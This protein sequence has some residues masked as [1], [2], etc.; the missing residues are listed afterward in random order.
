MPSD[1]M[2]RASRVTLR[3][4]SVT[5]SRLARSLAGPVASARAIA[6]VISA[7]SWVR[8]RSACTTLTHATGRLSDCAHCVSSV[9][10][11]L[12]AGAMNVAT[13]AP[14]RPPR[15]RR[16]PVRMTVSPC[17]HP[18]RLVGAPART[19]DS[20]PGRAI[21][22]RP[23]VV[24]ASVSGAVRRTPTD[25]RVAVPSTSGP[26]GGFRPQS[27]VRAVRVSDHRA[28]AG[29]D[30]HLR[31][32]DRREPLKVLTRPLGREGRTVLGTSSRDP[33]MS[34]KFASGRRS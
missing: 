30:R 15:R 32:R 14:D 26:R 24:G 11:P 27:A 17:V 10:L 5:S 25:P 23:D 19:S 16:S 13:R 21:G 31:A 22:Q 7:T 4:G 18:S 1:A 3:V 28:M 34:A 12:P 9:V 33:L 6:R 29:I 20:R 2:A 8:S